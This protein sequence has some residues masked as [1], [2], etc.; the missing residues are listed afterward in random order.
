MRQKGERGTA[1]TGARGD[2]ACTR[3]TRRA[4]P[5]LAPWPRCPILR[6]AKHVSRLTMGRAVTS[7]QGPRTSVAPTRSAASCRAR[8][9]APSSARDLNACDMLLF[10]HT[11]ACTSA[12]MGSSRPRPSRSATAP[13]AGRR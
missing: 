1:K 12:A 13:R 10:S 9:R 3:C 11:V 5:R 6:R 7:R 4:S 2:P 8:T